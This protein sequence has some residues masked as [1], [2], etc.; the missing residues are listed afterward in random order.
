M[1]KKT[2]VLVEVASQQVL[3][4]GLA[5][6]VDVDAR[7]VGE[8]AAEAGDL[9]ELLGRLD[10]DDA[11][12]FVRPLLAADHCHRLHGMAVCAGKHRVVTGYI[13]WKFF[14]FFVYKIW[15]I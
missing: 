6:R 3:L 9:L 13:G 4:G 1:Q 12:R 10:F 5:Q 14:Y 11:Q 7:G 2:S 15:I 8:R